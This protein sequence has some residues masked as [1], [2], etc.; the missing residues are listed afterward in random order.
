MPQRI[1]ARTGQRKH[2]K[3]LMGS[4]L[5]K[6]L[7]IQDDVM[8]L[9]ERFYEMGADMRAS[10]QTEVKKRWF[11]APQSET[12]FGIY[13]CICVDTLDR[14]K[15]NR[16]RIFSPLFNDP[17]VPYTALDWAHPISAMGGFDD[18]GL[19][20][21][22][23]AG[24]MLAVAFAR[25]S[26]SA[27]FYL[28][29][30]WTRDRG[31]GGQY[32]NFFEDMQE[33]RLLHQGQRHGY[34]LGPNDDSQVFP[35]W[36]T[37]NY[38]GIDIDDGVTT[39]DQVNAQLKNMTY[40]H[41]YGFKTNQKHMV[42]LD[43]GDYKCN[44]RWKRM[45]LQ[46]SGGNYFLLKDD[47]L[48]RACQWAHPACVC[49]DPGSIPYPCHHT[50]VDD[51]G[52]TRSFEPYENPPGW[53]CGKSW[54]PPQCANDYFKHRNECRPCRGPS[55]PQNNNITNVN[56]GDTKRFGIMQTGIALLSISGHYF[57]MDD[58]VEQPQGKPDWERSTRPFDY[59]C[60]DKYEGKT[61]WKSSTGH[62]IE[63]ND[64]EEPK[65]VRGWKGAYQGNYIRILTPCGNMAEFNDHT[66][67]DCTAGERRG[68]TLRSTSRHI[69]KM[70][71]EGN[72]QC[73][74]PRMEPGGAKDP[75]DPENRPINDAKY[76]FIQIRTGYGLEMIYRDD[77][78]QKETQAQYIRITAP[79]KDNKE[80]QSHIM[81]WQEVPSGPGYIFLRV[82]GNYI[83]YTYDNFYTIVGEYPKNPS[84]YV[85][86]VSRHTLVETKNYYYNLA[87]IHLFLA[88]RYI[89]LLA[90]E[91]C[92]STTPGQCSPCV[93]PV[94]VLSPKGIVYSDRVFASF[95]PNAQCAIVF[96]LW[97]FVTCKP[98]EGCG[99]GS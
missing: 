36:N 5:D 7:E 6:L 42:K 87:D 31:A 66:L 75:T 19:N 59:G 64:F 25:G 44:F 76:G 99:G 41:I 61:W 21:V 78:S 52:A 92:N 39:E 73:S 65:M 4:L 74:P 58:S 71:D 45:E 13:L 20:W 15:Q 89:F 28:G 27:P 98:F 80:R 8:D 94:L 35:Q 91:D 2:V 37:D 48:H 96:H 26:R 12:Y 81:H 56:G 93:G 11:I 1:P 86:I 46:S 24:S 77:N 68:I 97:P 67:P 69:I 14:L 50:W 34:L 88:K 16:V 85:R 10:V 43:D 70:M 38:Q 84:D 32:L 62:G 3:E 82:G 33:W 9:K 17:D 29:S 57:G 95:S 83:I 51:T 72:K 30:V 53:Q 22:P 63:M 55:T 18:S 40:P 23:P 79:Q 49:D 54:Y 90:G 47:H 60:T